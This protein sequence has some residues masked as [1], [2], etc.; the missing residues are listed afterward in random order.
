MN[1]LMLLNAL[2]MINGDMSLIDSKT[3]RQ[4]DR[5]S[6]RNTINNKVHSQSKE[7]TRRLKQMNRDKNKV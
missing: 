1:K 2:S 6:K 5:D 4:L 7:K 3:Q